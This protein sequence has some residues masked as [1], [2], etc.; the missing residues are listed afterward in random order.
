MNRSSSLAATLRRRPRQHFGALL[1]GYYEKK[2]LRFLPV[3]SALVSTTNRLPSASEI[4][5]EARKDCPFANLP[6]KQSGQWVLG[7]TPGMM[8]KIHWVNPIFVGQV[9][10]SE[11]TR[12]GKLRQPVFLGLRE[13]KYATEVRRE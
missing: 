8:R 7:I 5:A 2:K 6:S 11:W 10:F 9:K 1:V 4:Q 13:D 3:R 12:D